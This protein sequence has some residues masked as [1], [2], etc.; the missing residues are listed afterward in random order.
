MCLQLQGRTLPALPH[1]KAAPTATRPMPRETYTAEG[2]T[3]G[4]RRKYIP[5]SASQLEAPSLYEHIT[6]SL[7][8]NAL[9]LSWANCASEDGMCRGDLRMTSKL[10]GPASA[11]PPAQACAPCVHTAA[12]LWNVCDGP[13]VRNCATQGM[14]LLESGSGIWAAWAETAYSSPLTSLACRCKQ[15][16]PLALGAPA[17]LLPHLRARARPKFIQEP[18]ELSP[19]LRWLEPLLVFGKGHSCSDS[20]DSPGLFR[21]Q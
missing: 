16:T 4:M 9:L 12:S 21:I 17:H 6:A 18:L 10:P 13:L 8:W 7:Y 5:L 14:P 15:A 1:I 11:P 3:G 20:S 19:Q 2:G